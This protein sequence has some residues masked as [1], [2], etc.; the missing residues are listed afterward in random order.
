MK[1]NTAFAIAGI[2]AVVAAGFVFSVGLTKGA[3]AADGATGDTCTLKPADLDRISAVK[4]DVSLS[5]QQELQQELAVRRE[6]LTRVIGCAKTEAQTL[7]DQLNAVKVDG[8]AKNIQS[9]LSDK[10]G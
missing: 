5:P 7:R 6:L 10:V 9:Q 4:N 3:R 1:K 8:N 2:F